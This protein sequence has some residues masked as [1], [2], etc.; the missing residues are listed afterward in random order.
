VVEY[1]LSRLT[2]PIVAQ[3][4]SDLRSLVESHCYGELST[5][6][7]LALYAPVWRALQEW[8]EHHDY[9]MGYEA[10]VDEVKELRPP[11]N[12][13]DSDDEDEDDEW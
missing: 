3:K 8:A 4:A 11:D 9:L 2:R 7:F 5:A 1:T 13:A 12:Y 6:Q 10:L